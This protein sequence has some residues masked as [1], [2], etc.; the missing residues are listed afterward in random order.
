V[1]R[2]TRTLIDNEIAVPTSKITSG[3]YK[4]ILETEK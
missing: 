3:P 1:E 2:A 4:D